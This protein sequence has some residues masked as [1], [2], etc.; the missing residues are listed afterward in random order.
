MSG[1]GVAASMVYDVL[2][3]DVFVVFVGW[4]VEVGRGGELLQK[5]TVRAGDFGEGGGQGVGKEV[6]DAGR[7]FPKLIKQNK[8]FLF[9][10]LFNIF[11]NY[12]KQVN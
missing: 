12:C 3:W 6:E 7:P 1:R 2:V 9:Y 8:L 4:D 10:I 5:R 11:L